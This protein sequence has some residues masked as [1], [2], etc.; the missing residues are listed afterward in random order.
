MNL[1]KPF[2][3]GV[4]ISFLGLLGATELFLRVS[5]PSGF[6]YRHFDISGDMTSL[7]E[8]RDRL[9]YFPRRDP[10]QAPFLLL[11]DSVLGA[12]ALMEHRIPQAR[13]KT[14]SRFLTAEFKDGKDFPLSLGSDGLLLTDIEG[15]STEFLAHP[16]GRILLLLNFRMFAKDF[17][18]GPTALSRKFLLGD[19]PEDIQERLAPAKE[20]EMEAKLS[21]RL[22][23]GMCG[24]WFLFRESQMAKTLWYYP[25]QKDYFQRQLENLMGRNENQVEIAEAAL[26]QKVAS[27][28]QP[29]VWEK[30]ALPFE[31]LKRNLDQW[32]RLH[33]PV[34]VVLTPQNKKFLGSYLD[35][36]SFDKNRRALAAF[37]KGYAKLGVRYEDWSGRYPSDLF[38][39]HCH[40]T[41]EGNER[42]AKDLVQHLNKF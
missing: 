9:Q 15:L 12:S 20:P 36:A 23:G 32:T 42:Y 3:T 26:R 34:A 1:S 2:W 19:L 28:Y 27:Y 39:D 17:A 11:G 24:S 18:E 8:L 31:C 35:K 40:L 25:S 29:Y 38:L 21:D 7:A 33:I 22:Y 41:P 6:W 4:F 13:T 16:P 5:V 10:S 30:D 37:L 14:L